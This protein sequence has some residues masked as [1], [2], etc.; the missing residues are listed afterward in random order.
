MKNLTFAAV[1]ASLLASTTLANADTFNLIY[2][3]TSGDYG[4]NL[5]LTAEPIAPPVVVDWLVSSITGF[6]FYNGASVSIEAIIPGGSSAPPPPSYFTTPSGMFWINNVLYPEVPGAQVLDLWGLGFTAWDPGTNSD[7]EWNLFYVGG[8][9]P[10]ALYNNI[11]GS[12]TSDNGNVVLE[13]L[14]VPEPSIWA[15]MGL[16]FAGLAFAGYRSRRS[17]AAFA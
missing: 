16:G 12:F 11:G 9:Q 3:D 17:L 6:V 7:A 1:A 2:T 5:M 15:M 4:L 13:P 14:L 10:Y 8:E